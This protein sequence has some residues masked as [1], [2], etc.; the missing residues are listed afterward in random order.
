MVEA[1]T[2]TEAEQQLTE[3]KKQAKQ[4]GLIEERIKHIGYDEKEKV[5]R[6]HIRVCD[7]VYNHKAV[8]G[9]RWQALLERQE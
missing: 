7:G 4:P 1:T 6:A 9:K 8:F 5:W 3:L 2:Q